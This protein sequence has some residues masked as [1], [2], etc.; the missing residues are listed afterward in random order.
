MSYTL[1]ELDKMAYERGEMPA[2][3]RQAQQI[4]FISM[5]NLYGEY[6]KKA[7][8][9]EQSRKEKAE[10]RRA[11]ENAWHTEEYAAKMQL[12]WARI[13]L[14]GMRYIENPCLETAD[15]FY[16]TVYRLPKDW[17]KLK[18]KARPEEGPWAY[19][20]IEEMEAAE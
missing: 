4:Y 12:M 1:E 19:S 18:I 15:E 3:L 9:A 7:V 13:S 16:R 5:R 20:I 2:G 6:R 14:P 11:F 17:R 10:I 8:S